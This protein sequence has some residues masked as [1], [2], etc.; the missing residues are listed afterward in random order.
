[1]TGKVTPDAVKPT[2]VSVAPLIVTGTTP[3]EVKIRV[4]VAGIS[5]TTSPNATLVA[6]MLSIGTAAGGGGAARVLAASEEVTPQ[7]AA[8]AVP[9]KTIAITIECRRQITLRT[10]SHICEPSTY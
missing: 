2:P 4:W 10:V 1:V 8:K 6:L 9:I 3:A 5:I 7:P